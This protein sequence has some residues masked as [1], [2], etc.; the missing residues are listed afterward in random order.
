M[1]NDLFMKNIERAITK[2]AP[3]AMAITIQQGWSIPGT[4][5]SA[6]PR[7]VVPRSAKSGFR[8]H[9]V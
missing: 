9:I 1:V 2:E 3:T 6:N 8:M 5:Q 4:L 7:A